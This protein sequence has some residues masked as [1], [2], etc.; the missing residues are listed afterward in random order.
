MRTHENSGARDAAVPEHAPNDPLDPHHTD[1]PGSDLLAGELAAACAPSTPPPP[2]L[3]AEIERRLA[4]ERV[5]VWKAWGAVPAEEVAPGILTVRASR[6]ELWERTEQPGV[7][8]KRLHVDPAARRVTMLVRMAP[9]AAYPRHRHASDEECLV[10]E[11]TLRVGG[12]VLQR[13]DYQLARR[14]SAHGVQ[15]TSEGCLLLIS[16]GLDDE[17]GAL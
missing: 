3:F 10:L 13:G 6:T 14:G 1:L 12:Q 7:E 17:L 9:G 4:A 11:G 15:D 16:S 8:V 5:Q 2:L